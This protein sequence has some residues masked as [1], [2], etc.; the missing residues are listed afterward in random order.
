MDN[1]Y[2]HL[3]W[4]HCCE[5]ILSDGFFLYIVTELFCYLIAYVSVKKGATD[6]FHS[7]RDVDLGNLSFT[8][9]DLE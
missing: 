5:H 7:L 2:D 6:I 3:L 4:L 8:F 9:E 1:L